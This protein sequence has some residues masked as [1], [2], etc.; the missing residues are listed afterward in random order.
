M[1]P[2]Y[3]ILNRGVYVPY[4]LPDIVTSQRS[5][6]FTRPVPRLVPTSG[7]STS[8]PTRDSPRPN[9]EDPRVN[10]PDSGRLDPLVDPLVDPVGPTHY[11]AKLEM[12]LA[13]VEGRVYHQVFLDL[14]GL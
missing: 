14:Q 9:G 12:Q 2:K 6:I 4:Q 8:G 3:C 13:E 5:D 10:R 7:P 1:G 11:Q